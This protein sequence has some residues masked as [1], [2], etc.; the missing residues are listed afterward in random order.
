MET[1]PADSHVALVL[2][3]F[4]DV[5]DEEVGLGSAVGDGG[6][7]EG[8]VMMSGLVERLLC[9]VVLVL[10]F[11]VLRQPHDVFCLG[12]KDEVVVMIL[13]RSLFGKLAL[14]VSSERPVELVQIEEG[15]EGRFFHLFSHLIICLEVFYD[16][17]QEGWKLFIKYGVHHFI[18]RRLLVVSTAVWVGA[19]GEDVEILVQAQDVRRSPCIE[20]N[21]AFEG[22]AL[23]IS[24]QEGG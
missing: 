22:V 1:N 6:L 8:V 16:L 10:A 19:A 21:L 5:E 7:L 14:F 20:G 13:E 2:N 12:E 4:A 3:L 18:G 11:A 24:F 23:R 17:L 9:I 15:I